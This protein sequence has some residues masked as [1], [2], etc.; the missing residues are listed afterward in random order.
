MNMFTAYQAVIPSSLLRFARSR[1][2]RIPAPAIRSKPP[3]VYNPVPAPPV[4]GN[5]MPVVLVQVTEATL[6][7]GIVTVTAFA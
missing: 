6:P 3:M 7:S 4:S 5:S 2:R 1:S